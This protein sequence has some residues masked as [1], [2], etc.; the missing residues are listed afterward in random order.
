MSEAPVQRRK[1]V[2]KLFSLS[3]GVAAVALA[4]ATP[5]LAGKPSG[6]AVPIPDDHVR[7]DLCAF[8]VD[9]DY[10]QWDRK[11]TAHARDRD[12]SARGCRRR[13]SRACLSLTRQP[14]GE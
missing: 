3:V 7:L 4:L 14:S 12:H 1:T 11:I 5:T 2:R 13:V 9:F 10:L 6:V 8:P